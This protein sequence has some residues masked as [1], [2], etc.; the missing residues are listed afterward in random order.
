VPPKSSIQ[1]AMCTKTAVVYHSDSGKSFCKH[2]YL[3]VIEGKI[4]R[5]ITRNKVFRRTDR[6]VVGFSGGKDSL[7]ILEILNKRQRRIHGAPPILAL[8][9]DEG[10]EGYRA[11]TLKIAEQYCKSEGINHVVVSFKEVFGHSLDEIV[12]TSAERGLETHACSFCGV[13]RRK[14]LNDFSLQVGATR[15]VTGH[16]LDDHIQTFILNLLR[17]D[18]PRIF[19]WNTFLSGDREPFVSKIQPLYNITAKDIILY[20]YFK[21]LPLQEIPC[22]YSRSQPIL[23]WKVQNFINSLSQSSPEMKYNLMYSM[24]EIQKIA[25]L[26]KQEPGKI[27]C[28]QSC[29]GP[30]NPPRVKCKACELFENLGLAPVNKSY[31]RIFEKYKNLWEIS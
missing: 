29:E 30:T 2:C 21:Q 18:T 14:I 28:C 13:L 31:S 19:K 9:I 22:P 16:N 6:I 11:E 1:C 26:A 10:I 4:H 27:N 17:G 8:T 15:L 20:L 24:E 7:T 3:Q 12:K 25:S 5:N 23:R